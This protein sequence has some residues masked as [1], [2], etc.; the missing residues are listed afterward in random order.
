MA[1]GSGGKGR[2]SVIPVDVRHEGDG[3]STVFY[4]GFVGNI[5]V[6]GVYLTGAKALRKKHRA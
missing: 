6:L 1:R 3:Y 4:H 2:W 5:G